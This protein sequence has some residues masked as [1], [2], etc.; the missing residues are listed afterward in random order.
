MDQINA[1]TNAVTLSVLRSGATVLIAGGNEV[2]HEDIG[3]RPSNGVALRY[4][5][6]V[7]D[8]WV[9]MTGPEQTV[10]NVTQLA[11]DDTQSVGALRILKQYDDAGSLPAVPFSNGLLVLMDDVG[12]GN[13]GI[14]VSHNG[15]WRLVQF[16]TV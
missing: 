8:Q 12:S 7:D 5:K 2:L 1:I 13:P 6:I 14:A 11:A 15:N 16:D 10:V 3:T 9:V 4:M